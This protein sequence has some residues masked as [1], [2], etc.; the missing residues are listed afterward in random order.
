[1]LLPLFSKYGL[2]LVI[3]LFW[4]RIPAFAGGIWGCSIP[5]PPLTNQKQEPVNLT[6]ID[7][8]YSGRR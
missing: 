4:F 1:M 8:R 7:Y 2:F 6:W 3:L 5:I